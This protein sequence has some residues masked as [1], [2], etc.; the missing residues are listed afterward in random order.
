MV[1]S[2]YSEFYPISFGDHTSR[3]TVI[4]NKR[5]EK[6]SGLIT[7][8]QYGGQSVRRFVSRKMCQG[9]NRDQETGGQ[10]YE[11]GRGAI[12]SKSRV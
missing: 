7:C 1:I 3:D 5:G 12:L 11:Q 9:G 8:R 6:H 2:E 4:F 10:D